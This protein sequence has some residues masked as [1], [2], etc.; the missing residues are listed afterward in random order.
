MQ[1][2]LDENDMLKMV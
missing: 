2:I 1:R